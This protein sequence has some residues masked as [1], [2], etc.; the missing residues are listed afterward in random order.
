MRERMQH[1]LPMFSIV[2][3]TEFFSYERRL[4]CQSGGKQ[5]GKHYELV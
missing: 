5:K 2:T 4:N 1:I 3:E